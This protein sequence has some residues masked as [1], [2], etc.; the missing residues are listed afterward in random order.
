MIVA[1]VVQLLASVTV[2]VYD[3]ALILFRSSVDC[4]PDQ[5][6]VYGAVPP[7][8]V[9]LIAPVLVPKQFTFVWVL[10]KVKAAAGWMI[11]MVAVAVQLLAS[12]TV[13]EYVPE[14]RTVRSS[15]V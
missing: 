5:L 1:V 8:E 3:P 11:V 6:K 7:A 10:V 15:V 12:V 13:T 2:T 14:A 4:P 9:R